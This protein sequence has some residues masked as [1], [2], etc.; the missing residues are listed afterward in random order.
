MNRSGYR[1]PPDN[2]EGRLI[3]RLIP[4]DQRPE[5]WF[6]VYLSELFVFGRVQICS[7][8][9]ID[10]TEMVMH[11]LDALDVFCRDDSGL[12][13]H[14]SWYRHRPQHLAGDA[15]A[16]LIEIATSASA[17]ARKGLA[18]LSARAA[19]RLPSQQ[20]PMRLAAKTPPED[21]RYEQD[22]A[23]GLKE[24]HCRDRIIKRLQ[25]RLGLR[26]NRKIM[27]A[28]S[29]S[30]RRGRFC[31]H[32]RGGAARKAHERKP[33]LILTVTQRRLVSSRPKSARS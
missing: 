16:A 14:Q 3:R 31:R 15:S 6:S 10:P 21:V 23:N 22:K 18:S 33:Q 26:G 19:S 11:Q 13:G 7:G 28:G 20:M 25:L 5:R 9:R 29:C 12:A 27:E 24:D 1:R 32:V 2:A 17:W 8:H 4:R 30:D